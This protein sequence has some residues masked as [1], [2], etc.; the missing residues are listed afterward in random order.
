[1]T[2]YKIHIDLHHGLLEVEGTEEFVRGIYDEFKTELPNLTN[3]FNQSVG[4]ISNENA[5]SATGHKTLKRSKKR[6]TEKKEKRSVAG[7]PKVDRSLDLSGNETVPSLKNYLERYQP[8]TNVERNL[9]FVSYLEEQIEL[10]S[11]TIDHVWTCYYYSDLKFPGNL[12]Q[13]LYDTSF[14]KS[15]INT[16]SLDDLSLSVHGRNWLRDRLRMDDSSD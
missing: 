13:S 8:K 2:K 10:D 3:L 9:V 4:K 14:V 6:V 15:W 5:T 16:I 11:I 12:K 1:M 7:Q